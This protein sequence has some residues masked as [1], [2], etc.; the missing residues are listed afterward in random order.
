MPKF[1]KRTI[2][3]ITAIFLLLLLLAIGLV[4]VFDT[5]GG[6]RWAIARAN[7]A[8]PGDID[9]PDFEGTLWRGLHFPRLR[10]AD[11]DREVEAVNLALEINW[12]TL[13]AG[14]LTVERIE[15]DTASYLDLAAEPV[16]PSPFE[17]SMAAVPVAISIAAV[18]IAVLVYS[19]RGRTIDVSEIAVRNARI[20]EQT[21]RIR[22][23]SASASN[24]AI[25]ATRIRTTLTGDVPF[26]AQLSWRLLDDSWSGSGSISDSLASLTVEQAI[27]GP[28]PATVSGT[29]ALLHKQ[30]PEFDASVA[31]D[32]WT[33]GET[34]LSPGTVQLQGITGDYTA[35]YNV[36][37]TIPGGRQLQVSGTARGNT[38]KLPSFTAHIE[39]SAAV[40]DLAGS[41]GWTPEFSLAAQLRATKI[42]PSSFVAELSGELGADASIAINASNT[43]TINDLSVTGSLNNQPALA[44]GDLEWST[45]SLQCHDCEIRVANNLLQLDGEST[46]GLIALS[47]TVDAPQIAQLWPGVSG[48]A[49]LNGT[50]GG[51]QSNPN[52]SGELSAQEFA[53][54][55]WFVDD[56]QILSRESDLDA[57]NVSVSAVSIRR[58][59]AEL[60]SLNFS[61]AGEWQHLVVNLDWTVAGIVARANGEVRRE[62]NA[63]SGSISNAQITEANS[64]DWHLAQPFTFNALGSDVSVAAH[65]WHGNNGSLQVKRFTTSADEVSLAATIVDLPLRLADPWLPHNLDLQGSASADIDITQ[66]AGLWRGSLSWRQSDTVL[67]IAEFDDQLT[68]VRVPRAELQAEFH[69]SGMTGEAWLSIEPGIV[70]QLDLELSRFAAD[71]P[72]RADFTLQGEQWDW[73]SAV[74]PEIDAFKGAIDADVTASGPL[75]APEFTGNVTW[76]DGG[77]LV[78]AMNVPLNEIEV[79]ISGASNGTATLQGSAK[80]GDG[81]LAVDG[82]FEDLTLPS[83]SLQISIRGESA[84]VVNWPEYRL[85]ATPDM[86]ISGNAEG[87]RFAGNIEVPRANI[88]IPEIPVEAVR[89]SEDVSVLG[90]QE[91]VSRATR[92]TGETRLTL[93]DKVHIA[94]LGLDTRLQGDLLLRIPSNRTATAEGRVTLVDGKFAAYGQKLTIREGTLTFTGPLD[95]PLVDVKAVRVIDTFD[96][97]VTAGIY[98]RGRAQNLTSTVFSEPS[99]A[100]ADALSYLVIGRPLSQ[101]TQSEGG[102]LS[103]AAVALGLRQATRLT[104]QIGQTIG[105]D[106][107]SLTGDGGD[108]TALVAGK[109]INP[110]L[111]ARY[112]YGVFSR[113]G[114]LIMRYKLSQKLTLEAGAGENQ[115]I[116]VLYTV[117]TP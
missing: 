54:D 87:W 97:Q 41:L 104:E 78:P 64:G 70:G 8:M 26:V 12:T 6:T 9:A 69:G 47:L 33:F 29:V 50:L 98:L 102:E 59:N 90:E 55:D 67:Q 15:A 13:A 86:T 88:A 51:V 58:G 14:R 10:Y 85:W 60:G 106:Q 75:N 4:V 38:E 46:N 103:G 45:N 99:M 57:I 49:S 62:D 31:W 11:P 24:T 117:E 73:V 68:N 25:S 30:E 71:A 53:F 3:G 109:Q 114:T 37:A 20:D 112:A 18:D 111:Y 39:E 16:T 105:L 77:L 96:G 81:T 27:S 72:I 79:I 82:R 23:A 65:D 2:A 93:G 21:I 48:K 32:S 66:R 95:D 36:T 44:T 52:F 34:E 17:L 113:L 110:R 94:A 5:E 108:T 74:F 80:A 22:T 100:D 63:I 28:Y 89:V 83:R 84:E 76:R 7:A 40:V 19:S 61:G 35:D 91:S 56:L 43:V 42:D 116:D 1:L 101:A 107:L 115:S 92:V